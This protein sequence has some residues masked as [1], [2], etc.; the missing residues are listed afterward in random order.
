MKLSI[1]TGG[2]KGLGLALCEQLIERGYQVIDF[3]RSAPHAYSIPI[4]L[5]DPEKS[6]LVVAKAIESIDSD[7]LEELIVVSNAGT[8]KPIGPAAGRS[9]TDLLE[10]MNTNFVS[11]I[12]MLTEIIA[13]FQTVA[14]RKVVA[15][16]SSGAALRGRFGWSLYC[17]AKAGMENFVR[18]IALEQQVQPQP[19]IPVNIDPGVIDTDMQSLIRATPPSD[20]LD[21]EYFVKRKEQGKLVP[22][23]RVASA[24]IRILELPDLS[25]GDRYETSQYNS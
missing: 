2:S 7:Q 13:Q 24:V 17:A 5:A 10:N 21:V 3:S 23:D 25:S 14:C 11:A 20:F 12:L 4:D 19:F 15:N 18:S 1:V 22:P 8:L 16:I 6:R 9:H